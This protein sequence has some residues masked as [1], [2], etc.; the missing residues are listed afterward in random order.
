MAKKIVLIG[1]DGSG[2]TTLSKLLA[3]NL[4]KD[5][6]T[7]STLFMGWRSFRNPILRVLSKKH[8]KRKE[9]KNIK[10]EKL[11][12]FRPRSLFF[13]L[14][15]YSELWLRYLDAISS[16]KDFVIID[17]FF[18]DEL[19]FADKIKFKFLKLITPNPDHAFLLIAPYKVMKS[20]G[21]EGNKEN[22][23]RFNKKLTSLSNSF[24]IK[25]ID[26]SKSLTSLVPEI[27][28]NIK[29]AQSGVRYI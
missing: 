1:A 28:K 29:E 24:N 8:L 13:Y 19:A 25:V 22:L 5:N 9:K 21:Y 20:R 27:M 3:E 12:R 14:V 6:K 23:D 16:N 17:R 7:S 26:C 11:A 10:E 4:K 15:Y 18:F 2:K